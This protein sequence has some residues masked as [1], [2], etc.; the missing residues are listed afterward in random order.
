MA[1]CGQ[2]YYRRVNAG[3]VYSVSR[4]NKETN[5]FRMAFSKTK[6][7]S[8]VSYSHVEKNDNGSKIEG[9]EVPSGYSYL[10]LFLSDDENNAVQKIMDSKIQ[11]NQG[12]TADSY[13]SSGSADS[14]HH[15]INVY[16]DMSGLETNAD[17]I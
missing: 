1:N 4:E 17:I 13:D 6:P 14:E 9:I 10:I 11:L 8:G 16:G 3:E 15:Y 7:K 2:I 5:R 12:N